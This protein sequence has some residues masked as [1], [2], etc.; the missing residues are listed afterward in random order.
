VQTD[1]SCQTPPANQFHQT[2]DE[3][4]TDRR[5]GN[6]RQR[7]LRSKGRF[8]DRQ[9][10]AHT[11]TADGT[12]GGA[13]K[14]QHSDR[15]DWRGASGQSDERQSASNAADKAGDGATSGG[16][17]PSRCGNAG[18]TSQSK[19]D[20]GT[21]GCHRRRLA[22]DWH[23]P[24]PRS[25]PPRVAQQ[26]PGERMTWSSAQTLQRFGGPERM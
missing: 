1:K 19:T 11:R 2:T 4:A 10:S 7:A 3:P 24:G 14:R 17:C 15:R 13:D 6:E 18:R 16:R 5:S 22:E 21:G 23:R 26:R 12:R 9:P 20:Q 8:R 25:V